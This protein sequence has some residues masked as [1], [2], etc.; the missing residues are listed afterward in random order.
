M[1]TTTF[2]SQPIYGAVIGDICGSIY[3][4][5]NRKTDR[6]Q[7]IYLVNE[8]CFFTD[9]SILTAAVAQAIS[10]VRA[11][12]NAKSNDRPSVD[13]FSK[14]IHRWA[15]K[16]PNASYGARFRE[17]MHGNCRLGY[18][19]HGNGSAMRVS[20]VAWAFDD[21]EAHKSNFPQL[22]GRYTAAEAAWHTA[23]RCHSSD[24]SDANIELGKLGYG[25]HL[26][27]VLYTALRSANP[28]HGSWEGVIGA[29]AVAAAIYLARGD[30]SKEEIKEVIEMGFRRDGRKYELNE[31]IDEI[32]P[33]YSFDET[34]QGTVP[35]AIQ[36]FLESKD[37]R[38]AI[39]LAISVG[40]DSDT[41]AAITG[42]I[43]EAYYKD[44]PDDLIA[45][46][47]RKLPDDIKEALNIP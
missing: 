36:A 14:A 2:P 23:L 44:I 27:D 1:T 12:P 47:K 34:C 32:R 21:K 26:R 4:F 43:A 22:E 16:Y 33:F 19:S 10:L 35:V 8:Q 42:S 40:G 6:P 5:N 38:H 30:Y 46:A 20:P 37:F 31:T 18:G 24:P 39:Q 41:I 15:N 11:A 29:Q 3:E 28:T 9:D 7:D 13:D 25:G 45:F 17:W